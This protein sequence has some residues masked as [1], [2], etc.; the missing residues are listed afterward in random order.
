LSLR[1]ELL[2]TVLVQGCGAAAFLLAVV[3][4]GV[5]LG[6]EAQGRF[7]RTKAEIEFVA[8]LGMLGMPQALFFFVQQQ[9]LSTRRAVHIAL[10]TAGLAA[11]GALVYAL[12][13]LS[14][15]QSLAVAPWFAAAAAACVLHGQLRSLVLAGDTARFNQVTAAPQILLLMWVIGW[16]ASGGASGVMVA[17]FA[18][19][20]GIAAWL[21][22]QML[23][24]LH[25]D[26]PRRVALA[27]LFGYGTAAWLT[28]ALGSAAIVIVQRGVESVQG[29]AAL[30]VFAMALT[31][32][33]VPLVP[34]NYAAPLLFRHWMR[35][36]AD[37]AAPLRPA[38]ALAVALGAL[39]GVALLASMQWP[40]LGLGPRYAGLAPLLALLLMATAGEAALRLLAAAANAAG[41]PWRVT[42]AEALRCAALLVLLPVA[43]RDSLLPFGLT[44]LLATWA[45]TLALADLAFGRSGRG[46]VQ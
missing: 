1:R 10:A 28:A 42:I 5:T 17:G 27:E 36:A 26:E 18:L 43:P 6:P 22:L 37:A 21:A 45:A 30:G 25:A 23:R 34:V 11:L 19:A 15:G 16:S 32:A 35:R 33:Q 8:A 44:W 31:L 13:P 14:S 46:S 39:S 12:P 20:F 40:D 4:V 2:R 3:W 7:N 9:R 24:P 29:A 41:R 38:L